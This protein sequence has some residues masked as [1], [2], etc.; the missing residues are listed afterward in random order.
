VEIECLGLPGVGKTTFLN[1]MDLTEYHV[2]YSK[3]PD[4]LTRLKFKAFLFIL[5]LM[6][7]IKGWKIE[8]NIIKKL[9]YRLSFRV[10]KS[11]KSILYF[12]SGLVQVFLEHIIQ[13]QVSNHKDYLKLLEY[14]LRPYSKTL[15][16]YIFESEIEKI[17]SRELK[18][19]SRR[20]N[21]LNNEQLI[22]EY[23]NCKSFFEFIKKNYNYKLIII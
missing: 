7:I 12:D 10:K 6:I 2:I 23:N 16:I 21:N 22:R 13:N 20:F 17:I 8:K 4:L 14:I 19:P 5:F 18:R 3:N 9:A 15:T 11:N 1:K